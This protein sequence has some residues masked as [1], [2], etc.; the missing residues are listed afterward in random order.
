MIT[1]RQRRNRGI[2][3]AMLALM[4]VCVFEGCGAADSG[5]Q[6]ARYISY[7]VQDGQTLWGICREL[8]GDSCDIRYKI[9][10]IERLNG[11]SGGLIYSGMKIYVEVAE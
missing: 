11:I 5:Q 8:Y 2:L 4:A 10:D 9:H 7:E 3:F 1:R 6:A